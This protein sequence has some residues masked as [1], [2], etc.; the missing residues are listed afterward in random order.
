MADQHIFRNFQTSLLNGLIIEPSVA[1]IPD[2][3]LSNTGRA[4]LGLAD[5]FPR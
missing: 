4:T 2:V 3:V 5:E 1:R